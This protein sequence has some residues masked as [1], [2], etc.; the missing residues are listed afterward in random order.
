LRP[1][2]LPPDTDTAYLAT[3]R[4]TMIDPSRA[5]AWA[6]LACNHRQQRQTVPVRL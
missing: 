2:S 6:A 5:H 3:Q 1:T 4:T